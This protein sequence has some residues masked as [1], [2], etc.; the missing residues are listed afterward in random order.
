MRLKETE[1]VLWQLITTSTEKDLA[2]AFTGEIVTR[3]PKNLAISTLVTT[4]EKR[5]AIAFWEQFPLQNLVDVQTWMRS[6][7]PIPISE[8]LPAQD[9]LA[10]EGPS[11]DPPRVMEAL[12]LECSEA[13][14]AL[15]H[16]IQ[17]GLPVPMATSL[18]HHATPV[19]AA[20]FPPSQSGLPQS[21]LDL[22]M[23]Q[24]DDGPTQFR[25]VS[26]TTKFGLSKEFQD[27]FLW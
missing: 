2:T 10:S 15:P 3:V 13:D 27:M 1:R 21:Q 20:A 12:E 24:P 8:G 5:S 16:S 18:S 14:S 4:E 22:S 6:L 23:P 9:A 26:A 25:S 17:S 19:E 7:D 11:Q